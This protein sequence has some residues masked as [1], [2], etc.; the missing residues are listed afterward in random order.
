[1]STSINLGKK[2]RMGEGENTHFQGKHSRIFHFS[3]L[4]WKKPFSACNTILGHTI[5]I[6]PHTLGIGRLYHVSYFNWGPLPDTLCP[7]WT[8]QCLCSEVAPHLGFGQRAR[9]SAPQENSSL[10]EQRV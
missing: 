2:L 10:L 4:Q 3:S 7:D 1:M 5:Y 6:F 9:L 8:F